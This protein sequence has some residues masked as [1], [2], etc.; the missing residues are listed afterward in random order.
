MRGVMISVMPLV[1]YDAVKDAGVVS[2]IYFMVKR[3][4]LS[5]G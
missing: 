3:C 4:R 1:V 5:G 2:R